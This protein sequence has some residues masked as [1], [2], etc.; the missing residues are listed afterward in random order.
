MSMPYS[1]AVFRCVMIG[2]GLAMSECATTSILQAQLH[3]HALLVPQDLT[4]NGAAVTVNDRGPNRVALQMTAE[5]SNILPGVRT[6]SGVDALPGR[7]TIVVNVCYGSGTQ[8]CTPDT[9]VFEAQPG[10]AYVPRG[11]GQTIVMLDRFKKSAQGE[12]YPTAQH[13]FV[14]QQE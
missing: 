12:L 11:P 1:T 8:S 5:G 3:N 6:Q 13:A 2:L 10:V 4:G 14:S 7:H 9:Y